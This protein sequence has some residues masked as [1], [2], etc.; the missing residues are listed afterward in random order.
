MM[1]MIGAT[2]TPA[3]AAPVASAASRNPKFLVFH[4][5]PV[6]ALCWSD[7]VVVANA[8]SL[9]TF[10]TTKNFLVAD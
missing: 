1:E 10:M 4:F 9:V 7:G 2:K 5:C 8:A 3:Q 6:P